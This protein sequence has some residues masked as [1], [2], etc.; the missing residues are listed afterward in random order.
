LRSQIDTYI[1]RDAE[2][3]IL[4]PCEAV[5]KQAHFL[6]AEQAIGVGRIG[7]FV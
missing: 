5:V 7:E 1:S 4:S 2:R 6:T 3:E